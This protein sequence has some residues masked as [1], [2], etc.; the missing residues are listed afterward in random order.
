MKKLFNIFIL[1]TS[2]SFS[3]DYGNKVD[4]LKLC[5]A[6]QSNNFTTDIKAENA[7]DRI[8]N[9]IGASK[10]FVLQPCENI[11]NASAISYKGIRYI[12]YDSNFMNTINNNNNWGNLFILAHEV[13]HHINGHSVDLVL[14]ASETVETKTLEQKRI[15]EL[16][17]DE[18]AGF[19]LAKLGGDITEVNK[20]I[21]KISSNK[22][23]SNSTH[24]NA[25]KRINAIKIGYD[26]ALNNKPVVYQNKTNLNT[27]KEY[28]YSA[29]EKSTK[30]DYYGAIADYSKAIELDN[31]YYF[32]YCWRGNSKFN[33]KDYKGAIED[34]T[35]AIE[36]N[37]K[38]QVGFCRRGWCKH[39]LEDNYGAIADYSKAI[40]LDP[41]D[42]S[43]YFQR[44]VCKNSL[45]DYYGAIA[46]VNK[47]IELD[48]N[49]ISL[50]SHRGNYKISL[51]DYY[52]A[53]A[54]LNKAIELDP[55]DESAYFGRGGI[56]FELKD[57]YGAVADLTKTIELNPDFGFAYAFRAE[58]KYLINDKVG[59][60]EDIRK[61]KKLGETA[62]DLQKYCN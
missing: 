42:E 11:N 47:A 7:L 14:Y 46:D 21:N 57:Y 16:E 25:S 59:S 24:P 48:P 53:L 37:P 38:F 32:A 62:G 20:L 30:G 49:D 60:C 34:Y 45:K 6:M 41:N 2:V 29:Y 23:D 10:R 17:A 33:L 61:A 51:N 8:L 50:Y 3:Q 56:K 35:K 26:K 5:T 15:Q 9:V 55:N 43:A 18:F 4:A 28:F 27:A 40:E 13:G 19:I 44:G 54:D 1:I 52:G 12:L 36:L 39:L 58:C 31:Y 22:D